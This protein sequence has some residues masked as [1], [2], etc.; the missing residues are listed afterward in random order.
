MSREASINEEARQQ[1][2]DAGFALVQS[3]VPLETSSKFRVD[4]LAWAGDGNGELV[5]WAAVEIKSGRAAVPELSLPA[6]ARTRDLLGTVDNYAVVDGQWFKAD[7]SVRS[8]EPV[9]GPT[10]PPHGPE[11]ELADESLATSLLLNALWRRMDRERGRR[12]I[13]PALP[14]E[15]LTDLSDQTSAGIDTV[16]GPVA[17]RPDVLWMARRRALGELTTRAA[18]GGEWASEP[19]VARA[20]AELA[21]ASLAGTVLDPF[22]GTGS[23]LWAA[24]DRARGLETPTEFVGVELHQQLARTAESIGATAP[25]PARIV[26]GNAFGEDVLPADVVLTA[27]PLGVRDAERHQLLDGS[28]TRDL[29]VAAVDYALRSLRPGGRAVLHLNPGF[30]FHRSIE[31][32]RQYIASN[33]RVGA[34][35]GLPSGAIPGTVIPSV[36]LVI[37]RSDPGETFV[38]QLGEDWEAQLATGGAALTAAVAH[39]DGAR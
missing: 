20:V 2:R 27:P 32:F 34:L 1:L 15:M 9:D 28:R 33:Y 29:A 25:L 17:V 12:P 8:L 35:I 11:G 18:K 4:V 6:L 24:M 38:A 23:F 21:G 22:C 3:E 19:A 26:T 13:D 16:D 5:P 7:H 31:G 14:A 39:L 37:D 10:P 36:L 30:T